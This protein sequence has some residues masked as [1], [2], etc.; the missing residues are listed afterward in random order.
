MLLQAAQHFHDKVFNMVLDLPSAEAFFAT[1][2]FSHKH[3]IKNYIIKYKH[4]P[5]PSSCDKKI[6]VSVQKQSLFLKA[7]GHTDPLLEK[8]YGFSVRYIKEGGIIY[9]RTGM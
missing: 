8:G 4:S 2:L 6:P 5:N 3:C 1:D 9:H 7:L